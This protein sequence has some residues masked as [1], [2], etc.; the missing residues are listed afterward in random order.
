MMLAIIDKQSNI[1]ELMTLN[2]I[3]RHNLMN[4]MN[5]EIST[6]MSFKDLIEL[7]ESQV[8]GEVEEK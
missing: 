6:D 7:A 4:A 5:I 8:A 3:A 1:C 2:A